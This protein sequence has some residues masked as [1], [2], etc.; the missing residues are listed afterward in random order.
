MR[1]RTLSKDVRGDDGDERVDATDES[2]GTLLPCVTKP[3]ASLGS[4]KVERDEE[5]RASVDIGARSSGL[6]DEGDGEGVEGGCEGTE[7]SGEEREERNDGVE[8]GGLDLE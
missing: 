3:I 5:L 2:L 8:A 4:E 7:R 6:R 1:K